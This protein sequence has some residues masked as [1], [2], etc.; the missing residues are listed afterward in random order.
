MLKNPNFVSKAP[1]KKI[2]EEQAKLE[3]YI[4]MIAQVRERLAAFEG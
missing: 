3:K 1:Q 2:E 4:Q